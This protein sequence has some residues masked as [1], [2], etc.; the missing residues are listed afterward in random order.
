MSTVASP[1]VTIDGVV[2]QLLDD[3]LCVLLVRRDHEPFAKKWALA[4][5]FIARNETSHQALERALRA[6]TGVALKDLPFVEQLY[7]FDTDAVH[8]GNAISLIYFALYRG[9]NNSLPD[10]AQF[11]PVDSLPELAY[12]HAD[13]VIYARDRLRSK[14]MYTNAMFAL[15]PPH[16]TLPQLQSAYEAV[17]GYALDKRNFRKKFLLLGLTEMTDTYERAGAH[18]PARLHRF[19]QQQLQS[20]SRSFT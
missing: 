3:Q 2:F 5:G 16:F 15:L 18:R 6:K 12:N 19:K 20:L 4:G 7:T 8:G 13:I 9:G 17:L 14:V 11:F 10:T 1:V